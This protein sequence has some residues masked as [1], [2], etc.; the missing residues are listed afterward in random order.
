MC[1]LSVIT[2]T[3]G[4]TLAM[5]RDERI[6]RPEAQPPSGI[7][8]GN[9]RALYPR[10]HMGGTWIGANETGVA[11]ALLNWNDVTLPESL[12]EPVRSRGLV[13]PALLG[14][15]SVE[16]LRGS[17]GHFEVRDLLPFRLVS[18]FPEER[19]ILEW[20]WN[21]R[22]LE[23]KT[24]PWELRHWY[25]SSASDAE[26]RKLRGE[27]CCKAW[28]EADAGTVPWLRRLHASHA[29]DDAAFCICVHRTQVRTVS[30]T[31]LYCTPDVVTC[32]DFSGNPC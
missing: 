20:H 4:Y 15:C 3:D 7:Q 30:Y 17:I 1:T 6:S 2:R 22:N 12:P 21:L 5:N 16:E 25:S 28:A 27:T 19:S 24:W 14:C 26:A 23:E 31:E 32:R 8:I 11:L 29:R 18:V 10:D 9:G 13:I